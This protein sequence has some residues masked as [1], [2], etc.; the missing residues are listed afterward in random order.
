MSLD[1]TGSFEVIHI[2]FLI[3]GLVPL[4]QFFIT[5]L[6]SGI[7]DNDRSSLLTRNV[8][9]LERLQFSTNQIMGCMVYRA[10]CAQKMISVFGCYLSRPLLLALPMNSREAGGAVAYT[11]PFHEKEKQFQ[12][13]VY[14]QKVLPSKLYA[15]CQGNWVSLSKDRWYT[16]SRTISQVQNNQLIF[17]KA[18]KDCRR[19]CHI[20]QTLLTLFSQIRARNIHALY[21]HRVVYAD[22]L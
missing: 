15:N 20:S 12:L 21:N 13:F 6:A 16:V 8:F 9:H 4:H 5:S 22:S 7:P 10:P 19:C 11:F 1:K 14:S 2:K 17:R 3:D 18:S